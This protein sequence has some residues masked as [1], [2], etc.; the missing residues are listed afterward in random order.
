MVSASQYVGL[1]I[2][3]ILA[4]QHHA[5]L[6]STHFPGTEAQKIALIFNALSVWS[7]DSITLRHVGARIIVMWNNHHELQFYFKG[8]NSPFEYATIPF[9]ILIPSKTAISKKPGANV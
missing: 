2:Q 6:V 4:F 7:S 1:D 3:A 8:K 5:N 9:G